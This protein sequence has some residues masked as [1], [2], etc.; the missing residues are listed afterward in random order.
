MNA[1]LV[2]KKKKNLKHKK[3]RLER[4][5]G[6]ESEELGLRS[7]SVTCHQSTLSF[8]ASPSHYLYIR[9]W[10]KYWGGKGK[11][12]MSNKQENLHSQ[13]D[14]LLF[15]RAPSS[16]RSSAPSPVIQ[17]HYHSQSVI[18]KYGRIF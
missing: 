14:D 3:D 15:G 12:K 16:C 1:D 17:R 9:H 18:R 13:E 6:W 10:A 4:T 11:M 2:K 5:V 8:S 7:G